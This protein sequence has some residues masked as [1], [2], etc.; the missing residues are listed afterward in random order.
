MHCM[1]VIH[2]FQINEHLFC[3]YSVLDF[4]IIYDKAILVFIYCIIS[5]S[6]KYKEQR[7]FNFLSRVIISKIYLNVS[8]NTLVKRPRLTVTKLLS[9]T[10]LRV[11]DIYG[12]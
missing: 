5:L 12:Y 1:Y 7:D 3:K 4:I 8:L 2:S 9:K 11:C 6:S 10:H